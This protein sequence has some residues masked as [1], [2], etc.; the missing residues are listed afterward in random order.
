MTKFFVKDGVNLV[1][2]RQLNNEWE[3][4]RKEE[5]LAFLD[6][7][8]LVWHKDLEENEVFVWEEDV[9]ID[10]DCNFLTLSD[11]DSLNQYSVIVDL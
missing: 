2:D 7:K 10:G 5:V 8:G 4:I 6:S 11:V 9:L 3:E 1:I